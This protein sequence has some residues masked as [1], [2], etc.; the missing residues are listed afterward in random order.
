MPTERF[1]SKEAYRKNMAYRH[2][3]GIPFTAK[4]VVVGGKAHEVKHS[5]SGP[6]RR[7]DARQM[8]KKTSLKSLKWQRR[9]Q[10]SNGLNWIAWKDWSICCQKIKATTA[11][12][13][14]AF[15]TLLTHCGIQEK[16]HWKEDHKQ[17]LWGAV[18]TVEWQVHKEAS[19]FRASGQRLPP[20]LWVY[21]FSWPS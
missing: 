19:W 10:C 9:K 3:H 5:T 15:T 8:A 7:I 16:E 17:V 2:M 12:W 21:S 13:G 11:V 6:R 4:T 18:T 1:K 20:L 14:L